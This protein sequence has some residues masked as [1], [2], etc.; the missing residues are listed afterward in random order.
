MRIK[1]CFLISLCWMQRPCM[2]QLR[3]AAQETYVTTANRGI[4]LPASVLSVFVKVVRILLL[5]WGENHFI[6][7]GKLQKSAILLFVLNL[8]CP[9]LHMCHGCNQF[10]HN[11]LQYPI[12]ATKRPDFINNISGTN[13]IFLELH[14]LL[15]LFF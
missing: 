5:Y 7:V 12:T 14:A 8:T 13:F 1:A 4:I 3:N 11:V 6:W 10:N 15:M 9:Y 2:Q